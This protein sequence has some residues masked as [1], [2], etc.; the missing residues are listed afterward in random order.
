MGFWHF[1]W[2][3]AVIFVFVMFVVIFVSVVV[4]LFRS[5]DLSGWAKAG[6]LILLIVFPLIGVLIYLIV[7]HQSMAER[8]AERVADDAQRLRAETGLG[9]PANEIAHSKKLLDDGVISPEEFEKL[10]QKALA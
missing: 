7:R 8:G 4:D 2:I 3:M 5:H 10:K 9:S 6:W 1:L